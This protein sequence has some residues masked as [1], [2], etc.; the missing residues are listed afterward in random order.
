MMARILFIIPPITEKIWSN[1]Y[2]EIYLGIAYIAARLRLEGHK[3]SV[4]D[5]D[6][7]HTTLSALKRH[8][9][10]CVPDI[11]GI[12]ALYGSLDNAFKAA[13]A[14]KQNSKATVVLGGLPATFLAEEVLK[15]NSIDIAVRGEGEETFSEIG[16]GKEL[17]KI[18]GL[19]YKKSG[20]IVHN[21]DR[22]H[23]TDLDKL[24]IPL[25]EIFPLKKYK[26]Q[27]KMHNS[28]AI[29][30]TRGCP[31]GCEFCTQQ[32]KEG[33]I[34]RYRSPEM[35][36]RELKGVTKYRFI[37]RIMIVDNDFLTNQKHAREILEKIVQEGLNKR[38][39]YM[40]AT[41]VKNMMGFDLG[42]AKRAN[43]QTIFFGIE[44]MSEKHRKEIGKIE[45]M[46]ATAGL[47][48]RLEENGIDT[49]PSYMI[50]YADETEKD[51]Q[52]T[53]DF[54]IRLNSRLF[55]FN[56]L[57]PYPGTRYFKDCRLKRLLLHTDYNEYD[58]AHKVVKHKL[59]LEKTFRSMHRQYMFRPGYFSTIRPGN[60]F[61]RQGGGRIAVFLHYVIFMEAAAISRS[62]KRIVKGLFSKLCF[63][64]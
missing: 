53:L 36:I 9:R 20:K 30:T 57:T 37:K 64:T 17:S 55:S 31:Y 22:Q 4:I 47:F 12:T 8:I 24:G 43:V 49:L 26:I 44:S 29:E 45:S 5:C 58:N 16:A 51:I 50:G 42:L 2:Y 27:F 11:V 15:C 6:A 14:T 46:D 23:I 59:D 52:K 33:K 39:Y 13:E 10:K 19:S 62:I 28:T 40:F 38:F 63:E 35:V 3:V 1:H 54:A 25:R 61:K 32:P 18:A 34:L 21:P 56:I 41:R 48:R 60:I 7:T